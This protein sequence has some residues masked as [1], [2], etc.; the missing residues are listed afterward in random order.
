MNYFKQY[1]NGLNMLD[2]PNIFGT[3]IPYFPFSQKLR[4]QFASPT[5]KK[6]LQ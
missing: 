1:F 5:V 4:L 3:E 6:K 2:C